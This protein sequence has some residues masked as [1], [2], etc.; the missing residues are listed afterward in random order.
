MA[1]PVDE[2]MLRSLVSKHLELEAPVSNDE[3]LVL[4]ESLIIKDRNGQLRTKE[5]LFLSSLKEAGL[6]EF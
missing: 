1:N 2:T 5:S 4:I 3:A 6:V